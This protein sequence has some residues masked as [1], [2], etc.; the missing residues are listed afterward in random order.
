IHVAGLAWIAA[1]LAVA[2]QMFAGRAPLEPTMAAF[3]AVGLIGI[4][5]IALGRG[6]YAWRSSTRVRSTGVPPQ[7]VLAQSR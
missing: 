6:A 2:A 4:W 5:A 1:C 7:P 3:S